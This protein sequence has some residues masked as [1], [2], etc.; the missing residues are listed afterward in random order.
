MNKFLKIINWLYSVRVSFYVDSIVIEGDERIYYF[1][2]SKDM[3]DLY[4][5]YKSRNS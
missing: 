1:D 5:I 2:S 4:K 3:E